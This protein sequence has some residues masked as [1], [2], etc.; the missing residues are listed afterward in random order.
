MSRHADTNSNGTP[1]GFDRGA[2]MG[3]AEMTFQRPVVD[4]LIADGG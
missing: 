1:A 2:A 3:N 4:P